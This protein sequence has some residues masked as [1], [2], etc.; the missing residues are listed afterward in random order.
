M[1]LVQTLLIAE[2]VGIAYDLHQRT[3]DCS[4]SPSAWFT[5][6]YQITDLKPIEVSNTELAKIGLP[7]HR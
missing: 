3:Q 7:A 5:V 6:N 1:H 4:T 2:R